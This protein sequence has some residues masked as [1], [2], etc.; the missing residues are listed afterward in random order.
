MKIHDINNVTVREAKQLILSS[1]E[2]ENK[3]ICPCCG[4]NVILKNKKFGAIQ[5]MFVLWLVLN[6][7]KTPRKYSGKE[8]DK[9]I[10]KYNLAGDY[11]KIMLWELAVADKD[12]KSI[13][14][15]KWTPTKRGELFVFGKLEIP[16]SVYLINNKIAKTFGLYGFSVNTIDIKQAL[17]NIINY[18]KIIERRELPCE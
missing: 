15:W 16:E 12:S 1:I 17:N 7:K 5:A 3:C 18:D 13:S 6:Y 14:N 11:T 4:Q 2:L 10:S 9:I 8:F